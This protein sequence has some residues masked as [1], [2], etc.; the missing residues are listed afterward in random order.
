MQNSRKK[1][2]ISNNKKGFSLIE[3]LVAVALFS[4]VM[5][6]AVG[7]L[8]SLID[9]NRKAQALNSVMNNL[10][11]A[12]ENMSRN[13]RV[14]TNYHCEVSSGTPFNVNT[15]TDCVNGGELLAFESSSGD[16]NDD[17]D[18]V[19]YRINGTTLEKSEN[20]GAA[21]T[22]V[23]ITAPEVSIDNFSFYVY[24]TSSTDD[25]QP[26]VTIVLQGSAGISAKIR[27]EFNLQTMVSQRVLDI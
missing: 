6:I 19:V 26:R 11:F 7:A 25:F 2:R 22:F 8:L 20:A 5:L 17:N 14:G 24:G 3:M 12:L 23:S 16:R 10:N 1:T 18:Q 13:I 21:G 4:S 15:P 9:A 27:T